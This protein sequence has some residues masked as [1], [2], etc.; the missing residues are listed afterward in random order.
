MTLAASRDGGRPMQLKTLDIFPSTRAAITKVSYIFKQG[1]CCFKDG[2][3]MILYKDN[4]CHVRR[5]LP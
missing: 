5:T 2:I 3:S 4:C 1:S